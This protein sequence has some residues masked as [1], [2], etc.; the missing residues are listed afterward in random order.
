M[1]E[2]ADKDFDQT[3]N[4]SYKKIHTGELVK[5]LEITQKLWLTWAQQSLAMF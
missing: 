5:G 1:F 4:Q 3:L 2:Y